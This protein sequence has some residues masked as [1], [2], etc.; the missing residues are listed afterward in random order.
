VLA[1]RHGDRDEGAS[2]STYTSHGRG[3]F[4]L[5]LAVATAIAA[6]DGLLGRDTILTGAL[7][8]APLVACV[9]AGP[10]LT[11]IALGYALALGIL[12]GALNDEFASTD[13]LARML[14]I[15][16][17]G[18]LAVYVAQLRAAREVDNARLATQY[19]VARIFSE[20]DSLAAAAPRLLEA[21]GLPHGWQQGSFWEARGEGPL[22]YVTGWAAPGVDPAGFDRAS[23][24][25]VMRRGEGLPG[26][27]WA[28][29]A[30]GWIPDVTVADNFPRAEPARRAGLHAGVAFPIHTSGGVVGVMEF[31]ADRVRQED[32]ELVELLS[33]IGAQVG[34]YVDGLRSD[35][36]LRA[37]EAHTRAV[38]ESALD[39]VITIDH[40]GRVIEFNS[41]AEQTFGYRAEEVKGREMAELIV[42]PHLRERHR[43]ALRRYTETEEAHVLGRRLELT[44]MDADGREFPVEL[45]ITRIGNDSPP[46]FTG[47]LRDISDRKRAERE[48]DELLRLEQMARLESS[49]ARDQLEAILRGVADGVTAQA[50]DGRLLFAN[51]AAIQTLGF[52]S[53]DE[54]L[55]APLSEVMSRFDV[56]DEQ[57][58]P[59]PLE[60]LPGRH[61]LAGEPASEA[62]LRFRVRATGEER[63]S[64]VKASPIHNS[65]GE[66]VMAINVFEDIT[67]HKR[68]ELEQQFLSESTRVLAGS[69]DPQETLRQVASLAVPEIADWCAV[70]LTGEDGDIERVALVH[71]NQELLEKAQRLQERYPP[72]PKSDTGVAAIMRTGESQLY[73]EIPDELIEQGAVDEEHLELIREFGLRSAMAVPITARQEVIG[74]LTFASGSSGRRFGEEDLRMVEELGRRCGTAIDNSRV[75]GE[76][77]YIARALQTSLLPAELPRIPGVETAARFR[78]AGA[79]N[80]VGGDF[81]DLFETGSRGWTLVIGDVC[82]KG[83][84][85]AAVTA[86]ARYTLRAAAM[87]ERLPSRSL[88]VL[89]EALLRQSDDR[90]FCTVAYAYLE[91]VDEGA[92][93]GFASGG[94]PLP[95]LLRRDG[96][97]E[98]LGTHGML[99]GIVPDPRLEDRSAAL[100]PGDSLIFYTDGVTDAGGPLDV[101]GE[102]RLVELVASC[103]GLDADAIAGRIEA[104]ALDAE[105]GP[106]RD[107]IAVVVLRV[108]RGGH[109]NGVAQAGTPGDAMGG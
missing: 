49:Q 45:A 78:P 75:Y 90:R 86:L 94:H 13:H 48:R 3:A 92:R 33:A 19:A 95:V 42:P 81:Y 53:L 97:V 85:A 73:P 23:S 62:L 26:R 9:R 61:A 67:R 99:L 25:F 76:R 46:S 17:G 106:P 107:D 50:P 43:A 69:L 7:V 10:R 87:R 63:W 105:G 72:N 77:D 60:E 93:V 30:V 52:E 51:E 64:V 6:L 41:A 71:A 31:F 44:G 79:G 74:V 57:G 38:L 39:C 68:S 102:E 11:A 20:E 59:F 104:A 27:V 21:V 109:Q 88:R 37:S 89:N 28:S 36:A 2:L 83:P 8:A 66:V 1:L 54:L 55:A 24:R 82:G 14:T 15:V 12:S 22:R 5:G 100:A 29:D 91:A 58:R 47:Y 96:E 4:L 70:D 35:A 98:W 16:F 84:D 56:F 34:E 108:A 40:R 80:E 18:G 101:L 103:A 65:A 32:P